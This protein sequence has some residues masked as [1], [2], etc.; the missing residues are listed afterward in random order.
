MLDT[1]LKALVEQVD[2]VYKE[3]APRVKLSAGD[4]A[5]AKTQILCALIAE[6]ATRDAA[7]KS[8]EAMKLLGDKMLKAIGNLAG[9]IDSI[10]G[11]ID[12]FTRTQE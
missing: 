4:E 6:K 5:R 9:S 3:L 12:G 7:D 11:S 1:E 10:A 8:R 2:T